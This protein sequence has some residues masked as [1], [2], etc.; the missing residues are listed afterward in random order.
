MKTVLSEKPMTQVYKEADAKLEEVGRRIAK[1]APQERHDA[2]KKSLYVDLRDG[3]WNRPTKVISKD[4][5]QTLLTDAVNDYSVSVHG[6]PE[7]KRNQAFSKWVDC[8][9]FPNPPLL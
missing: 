6:N 3:L 8:P 9:E 4:F 2:R 7:S 5:A 1:R